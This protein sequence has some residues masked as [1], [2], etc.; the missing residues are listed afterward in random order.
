MKKAIMFGAGNIGRG[1]IGLLLEQAGYHVIFADVNQA[2]IDEINTRGTFTVHVVDQECTDMQVS[3]ISAINSTS[4]E[5]AKAIAEAELITT[6]VGLGILPRIAPAIVA[7]ISARRK[8]GNT[9]PMN[10]IACENA[11]RGTSQ[12]KVHVLDRLDDEDR[13][14]VDAYVGFPDCVVDRI[15]PPLRSENCTDVTV[16]PHYEWAVERSGI[17]G[18]LDHVQG[19]QIVDVLDA[20]LERKL[21]AFNGPHAVC[22][23][24][25]CRKGYGTIREAIEDPQIQQVIRGIISQCSAMLSKRHGFDPEELAAYGEKTIR[26]F[27]NPYLVDVPQ[28]VGREPLRK[29][30]PNDRL[31]RPMVLASEYGL[32]VDYYVIGVAA[33]LHYRNDEDAQSLELEKKIREDGVA[34]ALE[35][36]CAISVGSELSDAICKQYLEG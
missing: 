3:N 26:R 20:Y 21:F 33:A 31:I 11:L 6:A 17:K 12:L 32:P 36:F 24:L 28:R 18:S 9:T 19:M 30:S 8:A 22:A 13:A 10:I 2:V 23:Y 29:L 35:C 34:A 4:P 16:E 25:G 1:F 27:R 14:Y 5:L 7:G 15:V